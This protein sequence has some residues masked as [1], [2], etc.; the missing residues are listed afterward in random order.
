MNATVQGQQVR[1]NRPGRYAVV[2][3]RS[4]A[5]E[6]DLTNDSGMTALG[7]TTGTA[8]AFA[9]CVFVTDDLAD[10]YRYAGKQNLGPCTEAVVL[11]TTTGETF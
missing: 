10:A 8:P 5:I 3:V 2:N 7:F 4:E 6:L 1:I 11:D 9:C